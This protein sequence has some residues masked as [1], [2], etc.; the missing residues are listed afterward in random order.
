MLNLDTQFRLVSLTPALSCIRSAS[1]GRDR[2]ALYRAFTAASV[3]H[4]RI[5]KD[6]THHQ[7]LL[8]EFP[9]THL[10]YV[11]KLRRWAKS[12][13]ES[14]DCGEFQINKHRSDTQHNLRF[15]YRA[16]TKETPSRPIFV[17][18]VRLPGGLYGVAMEDAIDAIPLGD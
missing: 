7:F 1:E 11:F 2:D 3:L 6:V 10:P 13:L 16:E 18:F 17:K 9:D 12:N 8:G 5:L 4:A 15:L 14:D